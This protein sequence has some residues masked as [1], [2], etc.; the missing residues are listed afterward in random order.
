MLHLRVFFYSSKARSCAC[1]EILDEVGMIKPTSGSIFR[2]NISIKFELTLNQERKIYVCAIMPCSK[3]LSL[4][5][6]ITFRFI[7]L[8]EFLKRSLRNACKHLNCKNRTFSYIT[9]NLHCSSRAL[10]IEKMK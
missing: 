5:C 7:K 4:H 3:I 2:I 9:K 8:K 10:R 1:G 6:H